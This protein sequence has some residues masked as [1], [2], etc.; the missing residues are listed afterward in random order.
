VSQIGLVGLAVM[1]QARLESENIC[2]S[3][4]PYA[5]VNSRSSIRT[6][7]STLP[8][9]V[10]RSPSSTEAMTRPRLLSRGPKRRVSDLQFRD[11]S[12][13]WGKLAWGCMGLRCGAATTSRSRRPVGP[14][15]VSPIL[16]VVPQAWASASRALKT[17]RTLSCHSRGLGEAD[18]PTWRNAS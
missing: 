10:S 3:A 5:A 13:C 16:Y 14:I 4:N 9:R 8:R 6:W 2:E 7:R 18:Q 15:E 11:C 1:G 17:S 12:A